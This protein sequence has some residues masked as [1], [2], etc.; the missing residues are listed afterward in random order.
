MLPRE[1]GR[2]TIETLTDAHDISDF[3]CG[4]PNRNHWLRVRALS[5]QRADDSRTYVM[6]AGAQVVGFY[7]I[8]PSSIV[9]S[10]LPRGLRHNAP[11]PVGCVL[12]AQMAVA[13]DRRGQGLGREIMLHA[14][15]TAV[16]IADLGAGR[17]FVVHPARLELFGYYAKFE[18]REIATQPAVMA[19]SMKQVRNLL[20]LVADAAEA[21]NLSP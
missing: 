3:D 11:D 19:M 17:L 6:L 13:K 2:L 20:R 14:M 15:R 1:V 5:N 21:R 9:G 12:L 18:F 4:D 7:A 16:R 8:A 10:M